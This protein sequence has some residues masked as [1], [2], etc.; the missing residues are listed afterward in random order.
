MAFGEFCWS[1][2]LGG[3]GRIFG[4]GVAVWCF[5]CLGRLDVFCWRGQFRFDF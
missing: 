2:A 5:D 1:G 4:L 3:F